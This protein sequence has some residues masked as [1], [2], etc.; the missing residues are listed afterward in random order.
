MKKCMP[1]Q[2]TSGNQT[3]RALEKSAVLYSQPKKTAATARV[4]SAQ[5]PV[6]ERQKDVGRWEGSGWVSVWEGSAME[7]PFRNQIFAPLR[8]SEFRTTEIDDALIAKAANIGL[9]RIPKNGKRRPAAIG[10]P[11]AL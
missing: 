4:R 10:T 1:T 11:D 8:R 7:G 6:D 9:M 5:R 2:R 3:I